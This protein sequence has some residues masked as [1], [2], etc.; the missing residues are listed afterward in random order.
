MKKT[1]LICNNFSGINRT[2]AIYSSSVVT[3]SD[4]QNVELFSTGVNSGVGIRTTKGNVAVCQAIPEGEVVIN[5]FE[6]IQKRN[7]YFFVHTESSEEGKI[8]LFNQNSHTLTLK[9]SG[10]SVTGKSCGCDVSQGWSDLFVFSN[11]EELLSI[12]INHYSNLGVLDEVTMME[13][14]DAEDRDIKG[15]GVVVFAGRL[16][17][18]S[19]QILW[20]SVQEDIYDFATSS[21][22]ISTSAGYIEFV[23]NI[24]A[25]YP[26]LGTLA[27]F[28]K[29]SS[30]LITV[31][32]SDGSF[33]KTMDSPGGCAGYNSL[34]FH[35]TEL[36]FYDNTKKGVFCFRQVINGDKTLGENI[37]LDI[38]EELFD[39]LSSNVQ[40]IRTLSVVTSDRNEVWFLLPDGNENYSTILIYDYLRKA[41][42]KRKSQKI[43]C[44]CMVNN[45]LYSAGTK[46]YEEYS[47]STFDGNFIESFYK[48]APFNLGRENTIKVVN[49]PPRLTLDMYYNNRF[50]VEYVKNYDHQTQKTKQIQSKTVKNSLYFDQGHWDYTYFPTKDVNAIKK[51]PVSYFKTLQIT[52][53]TKNVGDDFC[54]KNIEFEK[55][56][57]K[58][59]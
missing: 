14:K 25:I 41:W 12:E 17:I 3:A 38:Q 6:S 47:S 59:I 21:A 4:I 30:T 20:Y 49:Y 22:D 18:F 27:V 53:L 13:L 19:N 46:I 40:D 50:Y 57:V 34:V 45:V 56:K 24:T 9:V 44:F 51:I 35:G 23:K 42:V 43:N 11:S 7:T 31:N 32:D 5:I 8:Y 36:Y 2:S 16:W 55:V 15:L 28:H 52:F 29:D 1:A 39:I 33:A 10:L 48:A 54:I 26:Y 58:E 37:A